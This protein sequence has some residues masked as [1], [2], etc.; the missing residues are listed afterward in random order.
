MDS[1]NYNILSQ[2]DDGIWDKAHDLHVSRRPRYLKKLSER[3]EFSKL[4][5]VELE[6]LLDKGNESWP[7]YVKSF[8]RKIEHSYGRWI[9][10]RHTLYVLDTVVRGVTSFSTLYLD[11]LVE[12]VTKEFRQKKMKVA[13]TDPLREMKEEKLEGDS[14]SNS[15]SNNNSNNNN[16][17]N[18]IE[19]FRQTSFADIKPWL[20]TDGMICHPSF[21]RDGLLNQ[22]RLFGVQQMSQASRRELTKLKKKKFVSSPLKLFSPPLFFFFFCNFFFCNFFF[23]WVRFFERRSK[24]LLRCVVNC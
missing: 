2:T 22:L 20:D 1:L 16:S 5:S 14:A 24:F 8:G 12:G 6:T 9:D 7:L 18:K 3:K 17:E 4:N 13:L 15:N 21:I 23:G 10:A 19:L 11:A